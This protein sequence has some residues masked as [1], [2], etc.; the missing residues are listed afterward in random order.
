M[1]MKNKIV[2]KQVKLFLF[3]FFGLVFY[4]N[5]QEKNTLIKKLIC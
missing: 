2:L 4:G 3:E 1:N 5:G